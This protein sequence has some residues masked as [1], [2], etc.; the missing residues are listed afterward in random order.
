MIV[1]IPSAPSQFAPP[2]PRHTAHQPERDQ[3]DAGEQH[4]DEAGPKVLESR[5]RR[6]R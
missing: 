2:P 3:P 6:I 1:L 4:F 5:T